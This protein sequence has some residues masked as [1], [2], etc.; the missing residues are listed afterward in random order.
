MGCHS[1]L[2]GIFQP[3]N[4]TQ[5]SHIAGRFFTVCAPRE[6]LCIQLMCIQPQLKIKNKIQ[7]KGP[8]PVSQ[9][10]G[11]MNTPFLKSQPPPGRQGSRTLPLEP[12]AELR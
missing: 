8:P 5:V 2:Q 3:R 11:D 7:R 12:T 10:R 1:L 4:R 6:A 9:V